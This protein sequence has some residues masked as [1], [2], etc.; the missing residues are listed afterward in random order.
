MGNFA[1]SGGYYIAAASEKIYA[2][3]TSI[4]GSIGVFGVKLDLSEFALRYGVRF[5]HVGMSNHSNSLSPF[6]PLTNKMSENIHRNIDRT[7]NFFKE[8]VAEGRH[9]KLVDV[10][11]IAQG[12][13][14]TG[15]QAKNNGL[16][17]ELGGLHRAIAYAQ[18]KY[19]RGKDVKVVEFH[20]RNS[21]TDFASNLLLGK[22]SFILD[23]IQLDSDIFGVF[24]TNFQNGFNM[25]SP[26]FCGIMLTF[27]EEDALQLL[28]EDIFRVN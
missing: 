7:Y 12:R 8:V 22:S 18:H 15:D 14:W 6:F 17:D 13:I 25:M 11:K 28:V 3:P 26:C 27:N 9:M 21:P 24:L 10:E 16:I 2:M 1:A 23:D 5:G 4:T 19:T 20:Q